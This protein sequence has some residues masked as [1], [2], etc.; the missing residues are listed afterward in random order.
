LGKRNFNDVLTALLMVDLLDYQRPKT[1]R[2]EKSSI[3]PTESFR[4]MVL[5]AGVGLSDFGRD[6]AEEVIWLTRKRETSRAEASR[7]RIDYADTPET[8]EYRRDMRDFNSFLA[9]SDIGFEDDGLTPTVDPYERR[10]S[11]R[12]ILRPGQEGVERFDQSG[13]LFGG[14]WQ[15]LKSDRRR[16]IRIN[17]E[18]V[19]TLD[20]ASAF[21]RLAYA[22]AGYQPPP[23]DV[24]DIE[25]LNSHRDGVKRAMNIF[26]FDERE[27]REWPSEMEG[28]LPEEWTVARTK[29][30]ILAR[31]PLLKGLWGKAIG[32]ELM[33]KESELMRALLK[34]LMAKG[35]VALPIHDAVL[36]AASKVDTV[37]NVMAT[38]AEDI[39]GIM[40][41]V[42]TK[43]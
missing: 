37:R 27:R 33:F 5:E 34:R 40:M 1:I 43:L 23:G 24:Y 9:G 6:D 4:R 39:T 8:A 16:G 14:F 30:A 22:Q 26:L 21:T 2:G 7:E 17:G 20:Y 3:A 19:A 28:L 32:Y 38:T 41:P 25:G 12:F 36:V 10:L 18:P 29:N 42:T 35:I 31:H 15:N 13:R 11:R